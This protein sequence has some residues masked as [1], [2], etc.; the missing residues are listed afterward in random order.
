M[1]GQAARL[2]RNRWI[3]AA[4]ATVAVPAALISGTWGRQAPLPDR[5]RES[6]VNVNLYGTP[7]APQEDDRVSRDAVAPSER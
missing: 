3:I 1:E 5:Y 6:T 4:I 7:I 2:Q